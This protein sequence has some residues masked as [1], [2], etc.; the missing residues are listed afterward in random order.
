MV[1]R[2]RPN[3]RQ[4]PIPAYIGNQALMTS[5]K[6]T[7]QPTSMA[8]SRRS[9]PR[10][11]ESSQQLCWHATPIRCRQTLGSRPLPNLRQLSRSAGS[12][13]ARRRLPARPNDY[14]AHGDKRRQRLA[15]RCRVRTG[16]IH[17]VSHV[18]QSEHNR[19]ALTVSDQR[20]INII[21][22]SCNDALYHQI[23]PSGTSTSRQHHQ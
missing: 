15:E 20:A 23:S 1:M 14:P 12:P 19:F 4:Y 3:R 11:F 7:S 18:V 5:P 17:F 2:G 9:A 6:A 22:Q 13:R 16:E 21:N 8:A 10:R